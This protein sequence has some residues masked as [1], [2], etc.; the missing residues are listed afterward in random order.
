MTMRMDRRSF[1]QTA[2]AVT[3][4]IGISQIANR[5][6]AEEKK[7][8]P[9]AEKLKWR[10]G[11]QAWT[12]ND[13]SF[14]EAIDRTAALG[15]HYIEAFPDQRIR[16]PKDSPKFNEKMP[17]DLRA[18]VKKRL[19]DKGVKL[20]NFGVGGYSRAHFEFAKDMGIETLVSEPPFDAFDTLD[21]LCEE[22]Q[23]NV[24]LHNHPKPSRYWD[25][26]I[27]LKVCKDHSKRIGS[28]SDTGHWM[29]SD[30]KPLDAIKKLEG[31]IISFHFKD[32]NEFGKDAHDV[33]WG[34]GRADVP[35]LLK[36]VKRQKLTPVFS[37]EYEWNWGKSMPELKE[38]VAYFNKECGELA[39][40]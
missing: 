25:P 21:K 32:L 9:N 20:V 37:V 29:R 40:E 5:A 24:G 30:I 8:A 12:F 27:V 1:L 38:C 3:A 23:I 34:T 10:L 31:H 17:A 33:P 2:G 39:K 19:A 7:G 6:F 36:E 26:D 14:Y 15:L 35:A 18:E 16:P 13:V 11:C 4:G 22:Y 28:T